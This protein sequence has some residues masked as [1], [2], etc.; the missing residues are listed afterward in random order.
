MLRPLIGSGIEEPHQL[1]G[2]SRDRCNI[3]ALVPIAEGA[4][5][6]KINSFGRARVFQADNVVNLAAEEGVIFVDKAV[7]AKTLRPICNEPSQFIADVATH[8]RRADERVPWPTSS[9]VPTA[10]SCPILTS[11]RPKG[12]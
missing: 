11:L 3:A 8:W 6:G 7:L 2:Y 4:G 5:M 10:C 1:A 12:R 9:G